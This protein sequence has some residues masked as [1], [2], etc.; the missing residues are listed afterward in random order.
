MLERREIECTL[1]LVIAIDET[2]LIAHSQLLT[3]SFRISNSEEL[4]LFTVVAKFAKSIE[5]KGENH[6][7]QT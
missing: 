1:Y 3:E 2:G 5:S 7:E 4:E 6:G